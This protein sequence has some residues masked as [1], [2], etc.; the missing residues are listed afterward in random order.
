VA[1]TS[2]FP[3]DFP[4]FRAIVRQ[5]VALENDHRFPK[6]IIRTREC[7]AGS[8]TRITDAQVWNNVRADGETDA[9]TTPNG[10]H[11]CARTINDTSALRRGDEVY[12][13]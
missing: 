4:N 11:R 9:T 5:Y 13:L 6:A 7:S 8:V 12:K 3:T 10:T 2:V 1:T